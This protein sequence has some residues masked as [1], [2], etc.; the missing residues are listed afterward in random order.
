[1]DVTELS[2]QDVVVPE[3]EAEPVA[4]TPPK[5]V[6][7][8]PSS[9]RSAQPVVGIALGVAGLAALGVGGFFGLQA[10]S[11]LDESNDGHCRNPGDVCDAT[12]LGLRSDADDA[13]TLS[14]VLV[15]AGGVAL[16]AGAIVFLTAPSA[17]PKPTLRVAF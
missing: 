5:L 9:E 8:A 4:A 14:T 2:R 16:V 7:H 15:I 6:D 10:K 12:G 3:L 1:M 11:K 17:R 13:A